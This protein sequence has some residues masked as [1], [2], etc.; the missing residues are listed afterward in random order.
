M[1]RLARL[2]VLSE[3]H[4]PDVGSAEGGRH[5]GPLTQGSANDLDRTG[6]KRYGTAEPKT[7]VNI[8]PL[9]RPLSF[10]RGQLSTAFRKELRFD[11]LGQRMISLPVFN[12]RDSLGS[13]ITRDIFFEKRSTTSCTTTT[14]FTTA[15]MPRWLSW[16]F[17]ADSTMARDIRCGNVS[18]SESKTRGSARRLSGRVGCT[19]APAKQ[20]P[21]AG[22][23]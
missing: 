10:C 3:K 11:M 4:V 7:G 1:R 14:S 18:G 21:P 5:V 12:L 8:A 2:D 20:S 16:W 23:S 19:L 17:L 22:W 15:Q 13:S 9:L 6:R